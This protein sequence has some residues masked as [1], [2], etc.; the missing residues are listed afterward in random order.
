MSE[1]APADGTDSESARVSTESYTVRLFEPGDR[2]AFLSLYDDVFGGGSDEWFEWK[3][4]ENPAT[5]HVPIFVA[6]SSTGELA[7]ARP[8]VPF[9][10]RA[11]D[12]T[13]LAF[14]FG[15]TMV[16][17]DHRRRG[18]FTR[19]ADRALDHYASM[20]A[21]FGFN[22]P[23][24]IAR[25]GFVKVGGRVAGVVPS[26]YR[27]QNP[28]ALLSSRRDSLLTRLAGALSTP[29]A[30]AYLHTRDTLASPDRETHVFRHAGIPAARL[31]ALGE[32]N[33]PAGIHAIRDEPFFTWRYRNPDWTYEAYTASV[34]GTSVAGVVTG[35]QT[36][37]GTTVTNV[38]D[39][40]PTAGDDRWTDALMAL[41]SV[42]VRDNADAD[43][44]AASGRV[45][46]RR[47]LASFGFH[48]DGSLPLSPV[49]S[50]TQLVVYDVSDGDP[51]W[52][53]GSLDLADPSNWLLS[54]A[55]LD[56]R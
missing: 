49:T 50:P 47:V 39:V 25:K 11:G 24:A 54:F 17:P 40:V 48:A 14:R 7:G 19:L 16:H 8:Q 4:V 1:T 12:R 15:D 5:S 10:M 20:G 46:P 41:F 9:R 42:V 53:V 3:Y 28:E 30:R 6:E 45:V 31:A 27:V 55:E 44:L 13:T 33:V 23:N 36:V 34:A 35:T 18:V 37:D 26:Y 32:R 21:S 43:L 2:D 51:P 22:C 29:G 52:S 56:A 38:V